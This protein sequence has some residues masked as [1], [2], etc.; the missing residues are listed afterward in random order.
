MEPETT[1]AVSTQRDWP[2]DAADKIVG[3]VGD[4]R[5]K[6]TRPAI[7]VARVIVYGIVL[8]MVGIAIAVLLLV[9]VFRISTLLPG[10]VYWAYL[11][12]GVLFT[13]IG[14]LLWAQ[15]TE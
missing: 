1:S 9:A 11:G 5:A 14:S 8:L 6:T 10:A 13:L 4:V 12:W 7:M 15:R 3:V 2:A